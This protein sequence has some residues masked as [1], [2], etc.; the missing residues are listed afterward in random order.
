MPLRYPMN[1]DQVPKVGSSPTLPV[2]LPPLT[3]LCVCQ[4]TPGDVKDQNQ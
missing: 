2:H 1:N 3:S 4:H